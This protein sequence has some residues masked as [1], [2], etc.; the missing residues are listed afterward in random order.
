VFGRGSGPRSRYYY[1]LQGN[2]NLPPPRLSTGLLERSLSQAVYGELEPCSYLAITRTAP[3]TPL[4]YGGARE[5][6]SFHVV[7]GRW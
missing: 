7:Q 2:Q 4:G 1:G 5:G 6:A 3:E